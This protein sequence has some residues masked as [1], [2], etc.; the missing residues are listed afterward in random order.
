MLVR[1]RYKGRQNSLQAGQ[2]TLLTAIIVGTCYFLGTAMFHTNFSNLSIYVFLIRGLE[3]MLHHFENSRG[4]VTHLWP[5]LSY[6][7]QIPSKYPTKKIFSQ[8]HLPPLEVCC[9]HFRTNVYV[10]EVAKL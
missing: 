6:F 7:L 2:K 1:K 3:T 9:G 8:G 5:D 4:T 10:S